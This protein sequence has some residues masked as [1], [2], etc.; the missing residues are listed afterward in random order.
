MIDELAHV[1]RFLA[2]HPL[3]R[4]RKAK[5][6]RRFLGFQVKARLKQE[7][8]VSWVEGTRL[9]VRLGMRGATGN[10]YAGLHDYAEMAFLLHFLRPGDLFCDVG[11]NVGCYT[12][13]AS[14][15]CR[16]ESIAF[17]P[18]PFAAGALRR[19]VEENDLT[20][21]VSVR[22]TAVGAVDG[23]ANFTTGL[24][25]GN[26]VVEDESDGVRQVAI[27][28]LDRVIGPKKPTLLKIDVE[29]FNRQVVEGA[30]A[31]LRSETLKAIIVE[32]PSEIVDAL[33][34]LGFSRVSYDPRDRRVEEG[35]NHTDETNALFIRDPEFVVERLTGGPRFTVCG[36]EL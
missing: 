31:T 9:V 14:G 11:A 36:I 3:T 17:E 27:T 24:G 8:I 5:A 1:G 12:V 30:C 19:N 35:R 23:V 13:L 2:H 7:V 10:V 22:E 16:A 6:F 20:D 25:V 26:Y 21:L 18:D 28:S 4:R 32:W 33:L 34:S 29:G 15:V